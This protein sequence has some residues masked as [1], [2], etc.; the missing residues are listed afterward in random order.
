M[1]A[2]V[3]L[4]AVAFTVAGC[5][6]TSKSVSLKAPTTTSASTTTTSVAVPG[7]TVPTVTSPPATTTTTVSKPKTG[8]TTTT[9]RPTSS[10][11]PEIQLTL[12]N[13]GRT[14]D[15][16]IGQMVELTVAS[17]DMQWG[18][19]NVMPAG[20][21]APD[22]A[23]LPPTGSLLAIWTATAAG[24]VKVN[25]VGTAKCAPGVACPQY[26]RLFTVTLVIT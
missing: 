26:A 9:T 22:P 15:V 24:T 21:L 25:A 1:L 5:D 23:P 17:S 18:G 4:T 16:V 14:V 3:T 19:L 13:D 7:S 10:G 8:S 2:A 12:A 20:L 6:G 11:G